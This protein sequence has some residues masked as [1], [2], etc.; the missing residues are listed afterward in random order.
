MMLF[1]LVAHTVSIEGLPQG[2]VILENTDVTLTCDATN[3]NPAVD[4]YMW[5][6][7]YRYNNTER[8]I[9][10]GPT[11]N[12]LRLTS[13]DHTSAGTYTCTATNAG[14]D[15]QDSSLLLVRCKCV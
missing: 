2:G 9:T 3:G 12:T 10:S 5:K 7:L 8:V 11:A 13:V 15:G 4:S 14:G 6:V 1:N